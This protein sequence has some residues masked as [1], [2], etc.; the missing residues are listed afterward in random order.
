MLTKHPLPRLSRAR[1]GDRP[2]RAK[3]DAK[4][5]HGAVRTRLASGRVTSALKTPR[6]MSSRALPSACRRALATVERGSRQLTDEERTQLATAVHFARHTG[7][8]SIKKLANVWKISPTCLYD[9]VNRQPRQEARLDVR[10]MYIY[11]IHL[12]LGKK[13]ILL[14]CCAR[15]PSCPCERVRSQVESFTS[16]QKCYTNALV[17]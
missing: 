14:T 16:R 7:T 11:A 8:L 12:F 5:V 10:Y 17:R 1:R 4:E 6:V 9:I 3:A 15:T 2:D 13:T